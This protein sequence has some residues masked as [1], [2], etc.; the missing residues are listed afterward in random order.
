MFDVFEHLKDPLHD[1]AIA[2]RLLKRNG[3]LIIATGDTESLWAKING[4]NWTFYNPPQH[5][6]YFNRVTAKRILEKSKFVINK[7]ESTGKWLSLRYVF[8]LA[9]TVGENAFAR[10]LYPLVANTFLGT[11]PLYI[12]VNDNM[13]IFAVKK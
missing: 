9:E 7:I 8:H 1:L 2:H 6:F 10:S 3:L 11:M 5:I 4:R 12:K 13:N